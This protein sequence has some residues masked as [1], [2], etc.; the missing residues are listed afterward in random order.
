VQPHQAAPAPETPGLYTTYIGMFD[1][2]VWAPSATDCLSRIFF[3][4]STYYFSVKNDPWGG[5]GKTCTWVE[6]EKITF[7]TWCG[8]SNYPTLPGPWEI[9]SFEV[10]FNPC[11]N[12]IKRCFMGFDLEFFA[13]GQKKK[14]IELDKIEVWRVGADIGV[15]VRPHIG[16]YDDIIWSG[17]DHT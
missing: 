7:S 5:G 16:V 4:S 9:V 15:A 8:S 1:Y 17:S 10:I 3:H 12:G 6:R 14:K 13:W 11:F 2:Q